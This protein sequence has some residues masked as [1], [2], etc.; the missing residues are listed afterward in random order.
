MNTNL[1]K[2]FSLEHR[3]AHYR[4]RINVEQIDNAFSIQF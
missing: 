4:D 1:T 2:Y 3:M